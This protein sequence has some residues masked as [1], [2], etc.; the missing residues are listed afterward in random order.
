MKED[1]NEPVTGI[2]PE[3]IDWKPVIFSPDTS[4]E[5]RKA[6]TRFA[7]LC[8]LALVMIIW[9]IAAIFNRGDILILGLP[10]N[11]VWLALWKIIIF[12]GLLWLYRFEY[13]R[14]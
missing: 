10:I 12:F 5:L 2:V 8:I 7:L 9:P 3:S 1:M 14:K 4:P 6:Y 11:L 13:F